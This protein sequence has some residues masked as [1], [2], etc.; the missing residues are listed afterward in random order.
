MPYAINANSRMTPGIPIQAGSITLP[1]D[2]LRECNGGVRHAVRETPLVVVPGHHAHQRAVLHLGLV[3]VEGR[4]VRIV[5][6]VDRDVRRGGVAEDA[7]E[8]LLG[9]AL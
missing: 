6:E 2:H 5:V 3:L 8:L 4:G 7:L 1:L 9:S